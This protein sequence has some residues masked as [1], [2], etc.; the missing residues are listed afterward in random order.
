[1]CCPKG[2]LNRENCRDQATV[3][4]VVLS[5]FVAQSQLA[6]FERFNDCKLDRQVRRVVGLQ[7]TGAVTSQSATGEKSPATELQ[8]P[9]GNAW[10]PAAAR[11]KRSLF[12]VKVQSVKEVVDDSGSQFPAAGPGRTGTKFLVR[13]HVA[14]D[15]RSNLRVPERFAPQAH[16]PTAPLARC[17][18]LTK[19]RLQVN[20]SSERRRRTSRRST[21]MGWDYRTDAHGAQTENPP[22]T[23]HRTG[24]SER[25]VF[26]HQQHDARVRLIADW[27]RVWSLSG[28]ECRA[29]KIALGS[30]GR[31]LRSDC[32]GSISRADLP[33]RRG[34][35]L[36]RVLGRGMD[37]TPGGVQS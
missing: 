24:T 35:R 12:P 29:S 11:P 7:L 17:S 21:G 6:Q 31:S 14:Q 20:K 13:E 9:M 26:R 4:F 18:R 15:P 37:R 10:Q 1:M 5:R 32:Q 34:S 19:T 3:Y 36:A 16:P 27:S 2:S 25:R 22:L 30:D 23:V 8:R 28:C 33:R